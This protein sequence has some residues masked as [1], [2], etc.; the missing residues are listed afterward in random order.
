MIPSRSL[1]KEVVFGEDFSKEEDSSTLNSKGKEALPLSKSLVNSL[2][3]GSTHHRIKAKVIKEQ[4]SQTSL[5]LGEDV[6][7]VAVEVL[8]SSALVGKL[9]FVISPKFHLHSGLNVRWVS[10]LG[11]FQS[12]IFFLK[13]GSS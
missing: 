10:F 11:M 2:N 4:N 9:C 7:M 1:S 5:I 6:G 12:G 8:S 3:Q 13:G